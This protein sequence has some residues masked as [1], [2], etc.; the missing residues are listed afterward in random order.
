MTA[1]E[2]RAQ[3]HQYEREL[4]QCHEPSTNRKMGTQFQVALLAEIAAQLAELNEQEQKTVIAQQ[5]RA[6]FFDDN[7]LELEGRP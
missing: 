5:S 1:D 7:G 3:A 2:I 6:K 4:A